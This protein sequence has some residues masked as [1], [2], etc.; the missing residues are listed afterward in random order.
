MTCLI[1]GELRTSQEAQLLK[2]NPWLCSDMWLWP[3]TPPYLFLL[4][5]PLLFLIFWWPNH[6]SF[7]LTIRPSLCLF[8]ACSF[9]PFFLSVPPRL[10]SLLIPACFCHV[11]TNQG[12]QLCKNMCLCLHVFGPRTVFVWFSKY[13]SVINPAYM[14]CGVKGREKLDKTREGGGSQAKRCYSPVAD[15]KTDQEP[16]TQTR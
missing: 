4:P 1:D 14:V 15:K 9:N 11:V 16:L 2:G 10:L 8:F 13:T 5:V 6:P 12:M 3:H 7:P